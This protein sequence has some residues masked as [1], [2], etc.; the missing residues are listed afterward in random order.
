MCH[1]QTVLSEP[2]FD[3]GLNKQALDM[4]RKDMAEF[5][6]KAAEWCK[7]YAGRDLLAQ[8]KV[9]R[10]CDKPCN[11]LAAPCAWPPVELRDTSKLC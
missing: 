4:G 11:P 10:V 2:S 7:V 1:I 5:K 6:A 8:P 3:A 9:L